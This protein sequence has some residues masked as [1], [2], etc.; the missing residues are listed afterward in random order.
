MMMEETKNVLGGSLIAC[1][2]SPL[3]GF[4]RDGCCKTGTEDT[5]THTVC[6]QITNE[7]L[8]YTKSRGND[9]ET[10]IPAYNFPGLKEGDYWCLCVLRW[11]EALK[12]GKAPNIKL[13]ATHIK[14]LEFVELTV[15]KEYAIEKLD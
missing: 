6:A 3:T 13:E 15:L 9:L 12:V 10:P 5:G 7:F 4:Y 2:M 8:A 14:S 11:K 1:S